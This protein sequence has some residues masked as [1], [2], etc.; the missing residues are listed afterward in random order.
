MRDFGLN[1][2]QKKEFAF[3]WWKDEYQ[4]KKREK[5]YEGIKFTLR[6]RKVAFSKNKIK[7]GKIYAKIY[8]VN[9]LQ[10]NVT[11]V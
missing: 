4:H 8:S 10:I 7:N 2:R 11:R 6:C 1:W 9:I 3:R 5:K